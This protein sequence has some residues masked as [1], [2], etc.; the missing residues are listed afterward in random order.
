MK[1]DNKNEITGISDT[2]ICG[3]IFALSDRTFYSDVIN[4]SKIS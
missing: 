1:I 2:N 4:I 3:N